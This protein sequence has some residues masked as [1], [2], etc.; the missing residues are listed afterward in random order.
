MH[1]PGM[2][3]FCSPSFQVHAGV[4]RPDR[5]HASAGAGLKMF[6]LSAAR[7]KLYHY[8]CVTVHPYKGELQD[9]S[10]VTRQ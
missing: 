2:I 8:G 3:P 6:N 4:K 1:L 10:L 9:S 5:V 7:G